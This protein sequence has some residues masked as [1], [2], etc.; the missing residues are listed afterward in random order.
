[1]AEEGNRR[2]PVRIADGGLRGGGFQ[3]CKPKREKDLCDGGGAGARWHARIGTN[4]ALSD[5]IQYVKPHPK[6]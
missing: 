5:R 2:T 6:L 1:M 4:V 3:R